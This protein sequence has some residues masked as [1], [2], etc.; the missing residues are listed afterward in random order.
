MDLAVFS[1]GPFSYL[2]LDSFSPFWPLAFLLSKVSLPFSLLITF[3]A[4][5]VGLFSFLVDHRRRFIVE[6]RTLAARRGDGG[7]SPPLP[8]MS[9][10][11]GCV[12]VIAITLDVVI[13][14]PGCKPLFLLVRVVALNDPRDCCELKQILMGICVRSRNQL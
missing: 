10:V 7:I 14:G 4:G 6:S 13:L 9:A 1:R 12:A 5:S 8:K 11:A 3:F 2:E